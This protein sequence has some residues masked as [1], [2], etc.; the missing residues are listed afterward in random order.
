[1]CG[2]STILMAQALQKGV[3]QL[4]L[5]GTSDGMS[6]SRIVLIAL[7]STMP[8]V[9]DVKVIC[10]TMWIASCAEAR[11][12]SFEKAFQ[13][14]MAGKRFMWQVH[15]AL[16]S[17]VCVPGLLPLSSPAH[18]CY[19]TR[20]YSSEWC[21]ASAPLTF[22]PHLPFAHR[23]RPGA[24]RQTATWRQWMCDGVTR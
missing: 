21:C 24:V 6:H 17:A 20:M 3:P 9:S 16:L 4:S 10:C 5:C 11:L 19:V 7:C 8:Y 12:V 18:G 2:Y 22:D 15:V 23:H 1:M 13:W 14:A